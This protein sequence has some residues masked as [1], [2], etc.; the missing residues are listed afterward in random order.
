MIGELKEKRKKRKQKGVRLLIIC[1]EIFVLVVAVG[2][3]FIFYKVDERNRLSNNLEKAG[4]TAEL[5]AG[6]NVSEEA[7]DHNSDVDTSKY[8]ALLNDKEYCRENHIFT[9]DTISSEQI[10]LAFAGDISFAEGYANMGMLNQREN[11]I[12]DCFDENMKAVMMDADIF[13]INNE[14]PYTNRGTPTEGKQFTFRAKPE[15][16]KYLY[17]I[18]VDI[19]SIA[20]NHVYDYG[21]ESL[22]DTISTLEDA[23]MPFVGAG[24]NLEEAVK[25][26]YFI[27]NDMKIAIVSATQIERLDRPDTVGA[28]DNS[29]GVFRCWYNERILECVREAKENSDYVVAYIHWGTEMQETP[30]WAQ[31]EQG[32][33]LAEAGADLII[34][35]H[36]HCLQPI[37]YIGDTP[38]IY[39]LGNFWFNSKTIDTGILQVIIDGNG[40][41]SVQFIPAIQSNCFTSMLVDNE[42]QRVLNYMQ[43]ISPDVSIDYDGYIMKK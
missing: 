2:F 11:K 5:L 32:K 3:G 30:D 34:G 20:N 1:I 37:T 12:L 40:T 19:V 13:M 15:S 27:A 43:S 28:T 25:P 18:G 14:F 16:V 29:P 23:A 10:V 7:S 9:K 6:K 36:P 33:Q 26:V 31:I 38:L 41:K 17:D 8:G 42:K 24:I 35:D 21:E 39:S 4:I 22:L